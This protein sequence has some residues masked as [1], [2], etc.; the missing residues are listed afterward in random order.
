MS[1]FRGIDSGAAGSEEIAS[2][3]TPPETRDPGKP[4]APA[5]PGERR[6]EHRYK[7]HDI[8]EVHLMGDASGSFGG[9]MLDISRSVVRIEVGKPLTRG[10]HL[11]IVL[12]GRAI[13]TGGR[14]WRSK[15][16]SQPIC[17]G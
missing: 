4:E 10:T 7:V 1:R 3:S 17:G 16:S 13:I 2:P 8:V 5:P 6:R 11:E 12:P 14:A 9:M 15:P